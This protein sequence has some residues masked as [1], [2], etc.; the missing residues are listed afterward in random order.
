VWSKAGRF[1]EGLHAVGDILTKISVNCVINLHAA[2]LFTCLFLW[3]YPMCG[4]NCL[5]IYGYFLYMLHVYVYCY[6]SV[7]PCIYIMYL[8]IYVLYIYI[9]A[10]VL[11]V[12]ILIACS[13]K[14]L[15]GIA[16]LDVG[17][18]TVCSAERMKVFSCVSWPGMGGR[19]CYIHDKF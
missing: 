16:Q 19:G 5:Y 17:Y 10:R 13:S 9:S 2:L 7:N 18:V 6:F 8:S 11:C 1:V 15:C 12:Y 4:Y 14:N 3:V